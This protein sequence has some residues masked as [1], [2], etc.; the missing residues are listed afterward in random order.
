MS[1]ELEVDTP[2]GQVYCGLCHVMP[3]G[4]SRLLTYGLLNLN[5]EV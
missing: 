5:G 3:D 2:I 1:M 4:G